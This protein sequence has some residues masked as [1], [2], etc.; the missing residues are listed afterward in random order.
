[1]CR[2]WDVR[3]DLPHGQRP[4]GHPHHARPD[5]MQVLIENERIMK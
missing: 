2:M 4:C 3:D 1:L 5:G